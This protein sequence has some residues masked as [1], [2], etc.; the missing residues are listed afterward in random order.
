MIETLKRCGLRWLI[1]FSLLLCLVAL[2]GCNDQPAECD[3][4]CQLKH[5][6]QLQDIQTDMQAQA[7]I[8]PVVIKAVNLL[9]ATNIS[10]LLIIVFEVV[11][12]GWRKH[13]YGT[14]SP[15]ERWQAELD[16]NVAGRFAEA[17][18]QLPATINNNYDIIDGEFEEV[19]DVPA[20]PAPPAAP[21]WQQ[22]VAG[23]FI[24]S[25]DRFLIGYSHSGPVYISL[26]SCPAVL[27]AGRPRKGKTTFLRL[28]VAQF[29]QMGGGV[30][31]FDAHGSVAGLRPIPQL[32]QSATNKD[33]AMDTLAAQVDALLDSRLG[34][35]ARGHRRFAPIAVVADELPRLA[36]MSEAAIAVIRRT[37]LEGPKVGIYT[38]IGGQGVS[39]AMLGGSTARDSAGARV[40]YA[41]SQRQA[42]MV[43]FDASTADL[44]ADL[45]QPG[46][47]Y[48]EGP[49]PPT[50]LATPLVA[51]ADIAPLGLPAPAPSVSVITGKREADAETARLG[52]PITDTDEP[53]SQNVMV[54]SGGVM[55]VMAKE[56]EEYSDFQRAMEIVRA[57]K[58]MRQAVARWLGVAEEQAV[59]DRYTKGSQ[60]LWAA[61]Q[62]KL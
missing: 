42:Y 22:I 32:V 24:P 45:E 61:L 5:Q 17:Q 60:S 10:T 54:R 50:L 20:L 21:T 39:A 12:Y 29:I 36:M 49:I 33:G 26:T 41:A 48:A 52:M 51:E 15:D 62:S 44:I 31:L 1:C 14:L 58:N 34:L 38:V 43:G 35:Y 47:C 40:C 27:I 4:I 13:V 11:V 3:D 25:P 19:D 2:S 57:S 8:A 46:L 37:I 59:G 23:G 18:K 9:I 28:V 6:Q 53:I 7:E 30:V 16:A 55:G 56:S